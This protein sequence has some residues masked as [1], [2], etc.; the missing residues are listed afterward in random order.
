MQIQEQQIGHLVIDLRGNEGG[1]P[2]VAC[3][4]LSFLLPVGFT[5]FQ[6]PADSVS[7]PA[8]YTPVS[9][10]T[11][12]FHGQLYVIIDGGNVSTSGHFVSLLRQHQIGVLVGEETGGTFI[13]NDNSR[14]F[15]C[16]QTGIILTIPTSVY[17]TAV[18]GL[19]ESGG[20]SPDHM[21]KTTIDDRLAGR[22]V[23][24]DFI[25]NRIKNGR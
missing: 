2:L 11:A 14:H 23:Q 12:G 18:F 5:Y 15:E 16:P 8:L 20:I 25:V 21:I 9:P 22:D 4:L 1:H 6:G 24:M 3:E 17:K 10:K 13:C 7:F 19:Y